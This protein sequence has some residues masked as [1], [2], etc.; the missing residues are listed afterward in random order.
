MEYE[1]LKYAIAEEANQDRKQY[2][3]LKEV[4]ATAFIKHILEKA[5]PAAGYTS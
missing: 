3:A 2:A 5:G 4:K 1:Q